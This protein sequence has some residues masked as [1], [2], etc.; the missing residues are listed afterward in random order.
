MKEPEEE[1]DF[2]AYPGLLVFTL[3]LATIGVVLIGVLPSYF[4]GPAQISTQFF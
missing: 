2:H 3:L 4:L 1:L